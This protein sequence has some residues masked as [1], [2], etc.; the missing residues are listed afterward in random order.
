MDKLTGDL[1]ENEDDPVSYETNKK[2]QEVMCII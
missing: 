2:P 1:S